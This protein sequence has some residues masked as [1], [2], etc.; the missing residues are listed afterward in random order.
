MSK[1]Q[2]K[3]EQNSFTNTQK[4]FQIS[5]YRFKNTPKANPVLNQASNDES[6]VIG[7]VPIA[8]GKIKR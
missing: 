1:F 2:S 6:S 5:K 4:T 7:A 8:V 3:P